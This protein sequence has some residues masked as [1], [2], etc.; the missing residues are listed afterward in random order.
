M[1]DPVR[2]VVTIND[3]NGHSRVLL[4]SPSPHLFEL[5]T[6]RGITNLWMTD[7][8]PSSNA[9]SADAAA[10]PVVLEPPEGGTVFRFFE[11]PPEHDG[12][13]LTNE[14]RKAAARA[15]YKSLAAEHVHVDTTRHPSMHRTRT[16]DYVILLRGHVGRLLDDAEVDLRP[17][18]A[19]VQRGT[20]HA[21]TNLGSEP[22]LLAGV[23]IHSN[24]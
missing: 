23:M 24:D 22:A 20:N 19:V 21:W 7:A 11:L 6:G 12:T 16:T 8:V 18:D 17:F 13:G 2:R 9:E 15:A 1:L 3:E 14:Q 10:R 5:S 4:D